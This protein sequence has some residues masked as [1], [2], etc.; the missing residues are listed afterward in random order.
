MESS[1]SG[2][3][4]PNTEPVKERRLET[5]DHT[6]VVT[7]GGN[8][9]HVTVGEDGKPVWQFNLPETTLRRQVGR[10]A[11]NVVSDY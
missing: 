7:S 8:T 1:G 9:W 5:D 4:H 3:W 10:T 11:T 6:I 2:V